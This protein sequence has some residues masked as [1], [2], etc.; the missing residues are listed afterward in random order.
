V[1]QIKIPIVEQNLFKKAAIG[2]IQYFRDLLIV[3]DPIRLL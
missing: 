1:E 2:A 3:K